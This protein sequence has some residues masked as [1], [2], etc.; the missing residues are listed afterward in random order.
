MKRIFLTLATI[1]LTITTTMGKGLNT[2]NIQGSSYSKM[3]IMAG[4]GAQTFIGNELDSKARLNPFTP[5]LNVE[6]GYRLT[7]EIAVSFNLTGFMAKGQSYY[8]GNPFINPNDH[9]YEYKS[10]NMYGGAL[11][12]LLTLDW[13]NI[14]VG[15]NYRQKPFHVLMPVGMGIA[16]VTGKNI[17]PGHDYTPFNKEFCL[18]GGLVFDYQ[19]NQHI[20]VNLTP[21]ICVARGSIDYSPGVNDKSMLDMMPSVTLGVRFDLFKS[22]KQITQ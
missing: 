17:N 12:C 1:L 2:S 21:K 18:I 16:A 10:F 20:A 7:Q 9:P 4:V 11:T 15:Y 5:T 19:I 3:Y 6:W 22:I 8:G 14:I 13:T